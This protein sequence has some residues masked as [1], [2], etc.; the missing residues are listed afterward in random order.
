MVEKSEGADDMRGSSAGVTT[1][2]RPCIGRAYR[3]R[4][5]DTPDS[6]WLVTDCSTVLLNDSAAEIIAR[7]DGRHSVGA[8]IAELRQVYVGASEQDIAEAVQSF[9]ALALNKGWVDIER[10]IDRESD[11]ETDCDNGL[12]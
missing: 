12:H 4:V 7:C 1:A 5:G 9:L 6:R 8:L 2:D 10:D 3:V 11:C